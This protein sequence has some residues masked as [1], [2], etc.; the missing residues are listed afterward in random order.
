M[1]EYNYNQVNNIILSLPYLKFSFVVSFIIQNMLAEESMYAIYR[2]ICT[3]WATLNIFLLK[4]HTPKFNFWSAFTLLLGALRSAVSGKELKAPNSSREP[5]G[6]IYLHIL[7][8]ITLCKLNLVIFSYQI[9][10]HT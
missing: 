4:T 6:L 8:L 3:Y 7:R 9:R 10:S 1:G 2:M 5:E